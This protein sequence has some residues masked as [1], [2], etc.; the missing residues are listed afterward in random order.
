VNGVNGSKQAALSVRFARTAART[1]NSTYMTVHVVTGTLMTPD[2]LPVT[3]ATLRVDQIPD[4]AGAA[5]RSVAVVRTDKNGRYTA[6]TGAGPSRQIRVSY[7]ANPA[8]PQIVSATVRVHVRAVV[9]LRIRPAAIAVNRNLTITGRLK[10]LRQSG[11]QLRIEALDGRAW[12]SFAFVKTV[13]SGRFIY[14]YRFKPGAEGRRF[15]FRVYVDSPVYPFEPA[16][17]KALQVRV[18]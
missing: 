3:G 6:T 10:Y 16:P 9:T 17:S 15:Y 1:I 18:R 8:N 7:Q 14:H 11:V 4:A 13:K 5:A 12:R 2:G